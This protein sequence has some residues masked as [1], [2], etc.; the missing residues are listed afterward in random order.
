M[1]WKRRG[2]LTAENSITTG[3]IFLDGVHGGTR[4]IKQQETEVQ[5]NYVSVSEACIQ[6]YTFASV[7][8]TG[9]SIW[10]NGL[11]VLISCP[12]DDRFLHSARSQDI[13]QIRLE[14][15]KGEETVRKPRGFRPSKLSSDK[16]H[17]RSKKIATH[18][19]KSAIKL[20]LVYYSGV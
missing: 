14:V 2:A 15:W 10:R 13:G 3:I 16:V 8:L 6:Y 1:A 18:R 4:N 5:R 20:F 12:D 7:E 17:E 19:I 11:K 9:A